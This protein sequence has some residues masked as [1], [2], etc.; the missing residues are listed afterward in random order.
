MIV[1]CMTEISLIVTLNNHFTSPHLAA[2]KSK[3]CKN[4]S[5]SYILT[6]PHPQW[7]VMS[8]KCEQPIDELT[9]QVRLPHHQPNLKYCMLFVSG[10]DRPTDGQIDRWT[11]RRS[12]YIVLDA[13]VVL[14]G[15]HSDINLSQE[16]N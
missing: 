13:P 14:L 4:L 10:T 15:K 2:T 3:Y 1:T 8:M 5:K 9:F 12:D 6:P 16:A 7:H 11:D